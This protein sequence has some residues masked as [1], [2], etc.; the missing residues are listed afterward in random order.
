MHK[1]WRKPKL[2]IDVLGTPTQEFVS[3]FELIVFF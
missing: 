2:K 1:A 3:G